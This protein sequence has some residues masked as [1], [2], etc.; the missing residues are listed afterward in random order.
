MGGFVCP[1]CGEKTD[2]F[3]SGGAER[4]AVEMSVPYLGSIPFDPRLVASGD[5]GE[6]FMQLYSESE[7]AK[8]FA[9]VVG[10][11]AV[12]APSAK[13]MPS[14]SH[15][16]LSGEDKRMR[17]AV[18]I[19]DGKLSMHFGHCGQF[20]LVDVDPETKRI[21]AKELVEAPDHQP[22]LLPQWLHEQG[23]ELIIAGGMG[24]RAQALFA[25]NDIAVVVGAPPET[26][27]ALIEAYLAG[28]L[29]PG[30]NVC[31]H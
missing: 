28:T 30:S 21:I 14:E 19:S 6:P 23:A 5:A 10:A 8:A 4:M 22:G 2:I 29:E 25:E 1:H 17:I 26:P 31:D 12:R 9:Q 11:L 24:S 3:G 20:A 16:P 15:R 13:A 18:P 27:D 7:A